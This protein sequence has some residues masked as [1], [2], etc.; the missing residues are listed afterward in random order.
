MSAEYSFGLHYSTTVRKQQGSSVIPSEFSKQ[1][2]YT[3]NGLVSSWSDCG[4]RRNNPS[5][6]PARINATNFSVNYRLISATTMDS[7]IN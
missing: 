2:L 4:C 3:D 5:M 1:A 7:R 6:S